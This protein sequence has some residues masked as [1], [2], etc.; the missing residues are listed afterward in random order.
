M[1]RSYR[2]RVMNKCKSCK[3][4]FE[5][6]FCP[7]CGEK[8]E[9]GK[10]CPNCGA[11]VGENA[12]F[13][14]ECGESLQEKSEKSETQSEKPA[15]KEA[16]K[17]NDTLKTKGLSVEAT[18][19]V[20]TYL[21]Y[22]PFAALALFAIL[23]FGL[24]A[25]PVLEMSL[26]EGLSNINLGSVYDVQD[27][28]LSEFSE[29]TGSLIA[30]IVMLVIAVVF[31]TIYGLSVFLK[32][33]KYKNFKT[34][35]KNVFLPEILTYVSF[36]I[37]LIVVAISIAIIATIAVLDEGTGLLATGPGP[38]MMI[39]FS[40]IF[41]LTSGGAL[42]ARVV[43]AKKYPESAGLEN[44]KIKDYLEAEQK[45]REEFYATHSKPIPPV[46][47]GPFSGT[48]KERLEYYRAKARYKLQLRKYNKADSSPV[49]Q[50]AI[51]FQV[52]KPSIIAL[53]FTVLFIVTVVVAG[54]LYEAYNFRISKVERISLQQTKESVVQ[55]LGEPTSKNATET[56]YF[57]Y[58]GKVD[59]K[60]AEIERLETNPN[61][62]ESML[63]ELMALYQELETME[64]NYILVSFDLEDKVTE[65]YFDTAH[66]YGETYASQAKTV[67]S[68]KLEDEEFEA[69]VDGEYKFVVND[70]SN[71]AY[72]AYYTDGS[73]YRTS[74]TI[75]SSLD[76]NNNVILSWSDNITTYSLT[77][78]PVFV[79]E[80]LSPENVLY[81][82]T[83]VI[84]GRSSVNADV[85]EI[86][87]GS[88]AKTI[89]DFS[90]WHFYDV[91]SVNITGNVTSIGRGAFEDCNS[92][93]T[94]TIPESIQH[95]DED[96]FAGCRSLEYYTYD[97]GN[98]LGNPENNTLVL[99]AA[100]DTTIN[101]L[102]IPTE[103]KIIMF[104]SAFEDCPNL[105]NLT[106]S[107]EN[108]YYS[109]AGECVYDKAGTKLCWVP[110]NVQE[111]TIPE[112]VTSIGD[113]AFANCTNLTSINIGKN[114]TEI[115]TISFYGCQN[116]AEI[117]VDPENTSFKSI[118]GNLYSFDG[119]VLITAAPNK[120]SYSGPAGVTTISRGAFYNSNMTS[121][122][123]QTGLKTIGREAFAGCTNLKELHLP[124]TV[125][126]V[127]DEELL[128]NVN[129]DSATLPACALKCAHTTINT[130]IVNGGEDI[131]SFTFEVV[132][133]VV[134]DSIR[135]ISGVIDSKSLTDITIGK[136]VEVISCDALKNCGNLKNIIIDAENRHFK[137]IDGN[138]Y[139]YDGTIFYYY[140]AWKTEESFV[141]PNGVRI[142]EDDAF[143]GYW[144]TKSNTALKTI[145]IPESISLIFP[146]AFYG[147]RLDEIVFEG[148]S[149]WEEL[150]TFWDND[151]IKREFN[152]AKTS[153]LRNG[154]SNLINVVWDDREEYVYERDY[155]GFRES[156]R[157][158]STAFATYMSE[159]VAKH[160]L[161]Y[162]N[163]AWQRL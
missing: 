140:A 49:S 7:N 48:H 97:N 8:F 91:Q 57:W 144:L 139:S 114:I 30:L 86:V 63:S 136:N 60:L 1:I 158:D 73:Y 93:K 56:T 104:K 62:S 21:K 44:Q 34:G 99:M 83:E 46:K 68:V 16:P 5:G 92:L 15:K 156:Q 19:K 70:L 124:A 26:G 13:C 115:G 52:Y 152:N 17:T 109:K 155:Y 65:V 53:I 3:T 153:S 130:L 32:K 113:Y 149:S 54:V 108:Q 23:L 121:I 122:T 41:A 40:A 119:S 137:T 76:P 80:Y 142:I 14:N 71:F 138:L 47:I 25:A 10:K 127:E 128:S 58:D 84:Y 66:R 29:L 118:D 88:K 95:I 151:K 36:A 106:V 28:A 37:Y 141:I 111:F 145:T 150:T 81:L 134:G 162:S 87:L 50:K 59:E 129:L 9:G 22:A 64:Y 27:F 79:S 77:K 132:N 75:S 12:K 125:T 45:R 163:L 135:Y 105:T 123:F 6:K 74:K 161:T 18:Q 39:V 2:G 35:Q 131:G 20:Y 112:N 101:S 147:L 159:L 51:T 116:L 33:L 102:E 31:A 110:Q 146:G 94:I 160:F 107:A 85:T 72:Q 100:T 120:T 117:T 11:A 82:N 103:T 42:I 24:F 98:Y 143:C 43:M 148:S 89:A 126:E 55:L 69:Y 90:F 4:E 154:S 61:F 133:L 38:I 96:A 78:Q 157:F 67:Q